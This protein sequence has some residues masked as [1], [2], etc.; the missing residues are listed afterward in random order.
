MKAFQ[1]KLRYLMCVLKLLLF[2]QGERKFSVYLAEV[3]CR[4]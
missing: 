2:I 1:I 4:L 3:G